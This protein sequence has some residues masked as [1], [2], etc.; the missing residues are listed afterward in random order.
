MI[1]NS[2]VFRN[3][4]IGLKKKKFR[5]KEGEGGA[6]KVIFLRYYLIKKR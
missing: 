6:V 2:V 1:L 3:Y 4:R 5:G